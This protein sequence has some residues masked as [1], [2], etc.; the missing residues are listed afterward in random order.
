MKESV[1]DALV[2]PTKDKPWLWAVYVLVILVPIVLIIVFCCGKSTPAENE[3]PAKVDAAEA[4]K[5]DAVTKDDEE[6]KESE[7]SREEEAE[8]EN[9]TDSDEM[10]K[11]SKEDLEAEVIDDES[12]V[13]FISK[14]KR[15]P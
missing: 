2:N 11:V 14:N 13:R 5:T 15:M 1:I 9:A 7:P 8:E 4:K 10:H 3:S 6:T 12:E